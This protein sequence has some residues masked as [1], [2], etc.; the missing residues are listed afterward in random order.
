MTRI[1]FYRKNMF[2]ADLVL[3]FRR[4]FWW[5]LITPK[6]SW[7]RTASKYVPKHF[8]K[9]CENVKENMYTNLQIIYR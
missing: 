4:H 9:E 8:I 2:L 7:I 5:G 6:L 1:I 3:F